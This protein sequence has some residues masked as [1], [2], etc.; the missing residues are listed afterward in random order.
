MTAIIWTLVGL[1]G[2][3][4]LGATVLATMDDDS[5]TLLRWARG[6]P[7]GGATAVMLA[8]PLTVWWILHLTAVN[9]KPRH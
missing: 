1:M 6:C 4:F 2:W 7:F 9:K 3:L 8:W 5:G